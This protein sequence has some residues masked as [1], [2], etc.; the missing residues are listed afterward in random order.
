MKSYL[1]PQ[2][3]NLEKL[4]SKDHTYPMTP[5]DVPDGFREISEGLWAGPYGKVNF[6]FKMPSMN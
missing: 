2:D 5:F 4:E 3:F 1:W 6:L